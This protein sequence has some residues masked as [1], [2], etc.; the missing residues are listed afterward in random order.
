MAKQERENLKNSNMK[1]TLHWGNKIANEVTCSY[2]LVEPCFLFCNLLAR[3]CKGRTLCS[4]GSAFGHE[5]A[6]SVPAQ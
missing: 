6:E 4:Q 2:M 3:I 5:S 1:V